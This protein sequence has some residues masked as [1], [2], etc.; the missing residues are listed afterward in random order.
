MAK[1]Q[2]QIWNIMYQKCSEEEQ[3]FVQK[4]IDCF[5]NQDTPVYNIKILQF[6]VR[7]ALVMNLFLC[8]LLYREKNNLKDYFFNQSYINTIWFVSICLQNAIVLVPKIFMMV[9][10]QI[11]LNNTYNTDELVVNIEEFMKTKIYY[12]NCYI[13]KYIWMNY[14]IG[15]VLYLFNIAVG[16]Y[17]FENSQIVS[18]CNFV[19]YLMIARLIL[20][21]AKVTLQSKGL[22]EQQL[23]NLINKRQFTVNED[24]CKKHEDCCSICLEEYLVGQISLQLDCKHI[25]HISCIKTW[26]KQQNKCACCNQ[27]A[28]REL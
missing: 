25:Y 2:N 5:K 13:S 24:F 8:Y 20:F 3:K 12:Q 7:V 18:L 19:L 6:Q 17:E 15:G 26:L 16:F 27:F 11:V 4:Q 23:T 1:L 10:L 21:I 9:I 28:F 22:T 14:G